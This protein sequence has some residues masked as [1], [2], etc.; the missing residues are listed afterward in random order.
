MIDMMPN[1]TFYFASHQVWNMTLF[2]YRFDRKQHGCTVPLNG[3]IIGK[4][5][6]WVDV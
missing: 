1:L 4:G 3:N 2:L 6:I 5:L